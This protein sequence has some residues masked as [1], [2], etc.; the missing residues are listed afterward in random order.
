MFLPETEYGTN[1]ILE[2][3][4]NFIVFYEKHKIMVHP[5]SSWMKQVNVMSLFSAKDSS[6]KAFKQVKIE[7]YIEK[8]VATSKH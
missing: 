3:W 2:N 4:S 1:F 7:Q 6:S 8:P 5:S